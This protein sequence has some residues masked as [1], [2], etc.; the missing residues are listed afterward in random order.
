MGEIVASAPIMSVRA[1]KPNRKIASL[2]M[3]SP[4]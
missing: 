3:V 1:R 4:E 2:A